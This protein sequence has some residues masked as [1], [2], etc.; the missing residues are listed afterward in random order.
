[1]GDDSENRSSDARFDYIKNRI[2]FAFPKLAGAKLDKMLMADDVREA[3]AAFCD[4]EHNRCLVVPESMK[5]DKVIPSKLSKGKILLF[6]KLNSCV[7][8]EKNITSSVSLLI[9]NVTFILI[10]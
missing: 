10:F 2:N 1:M 8:N 5:M 6:I 4:Y 3:F 9:P 7:L